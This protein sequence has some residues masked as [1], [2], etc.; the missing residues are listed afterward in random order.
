MYAF[1]DKVYTNAV[2]WRS[3]LN[4]SALN[5]IR[6]VVGNLIQCTSSTSD[7]AYLTSFL[8]LRDSPKADRS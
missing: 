5:P 3:L 7:A 4:Q 2:V 1:K 6:D 8:G